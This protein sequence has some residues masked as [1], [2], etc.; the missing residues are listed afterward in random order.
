MYHTPSQTRAVNKI[1]NTSNKKPKKKTEAQIFQKK[2][3]QATHK[4]PDGTIMTGAKHS[5]SSKSIR[6]KKKNKKNTY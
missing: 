6:K 5:S 3:K 1:L 4:M 2:K